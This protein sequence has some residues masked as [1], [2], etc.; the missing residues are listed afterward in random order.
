M[1]DALQLRENAKYELE[2][3][4]D[5]ETGINYLNKVKA[6]EV[7]AK[8]E[9]KDAELQNMIAE[10]K[11]RTQRILGNLLKESEFRKNQYD[12][13]REDRPPLSDYGITKDQSSTFQKIADIP[14]QTFEDYIKEKKEAVN[15]AV[16]E[17]T[18]TGALKLAKSLKDKK[19]DVKTEHD[20]N[21][22]LDLERE[23][24]EL[25]TSLKKK[26]KADMIELLVKLLNK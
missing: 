10:Q 9:K 6:I 26:Y 4:R 20:L 24:R 3:I 11:I 22:R 17:L 12:A 13:G 7:W 25:A 19:Q 1:T 15:N 8:A 16:A 23:I 2:Q 14:E 18:T 21:I 5:L